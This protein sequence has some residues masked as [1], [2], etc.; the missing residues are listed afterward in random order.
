MKT[1]QQLRAT[2]YLPGGS[3]SHCLDVTPGKDEKDKDD[4]R[5]WS[6]DVASNLSMAVITRQTLLTAGLEERRDRPSEPA[7]GGGRDKVASLHRLQTE[8]SV[9]NLN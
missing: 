2:G 6:S 3:L 9:L 7:Q 5:D 1:L 8:I 4:S